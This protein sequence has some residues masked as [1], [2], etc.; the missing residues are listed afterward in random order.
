MRKAGLL[1]LGFVLATSALVLASAPILT[2]TMGIAVEVAP[3]TIVLHA[4]GPTWVTAH[5]DIPYDQVDAGTVYLD[6][7]PAMRTEA[8]LCGNLV[9]L[10]A[11]GDVKEMLE[12]GHQTLTLTGL[13]V[14][15]EP[16]AGSDTVL[17]RP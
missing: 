12:P 9:A 8:D 5:A 10:F 1:S 14:D 4:D 6:G 2:A 11:G 15:E 3:R 13:T 17:V 16:F 7:I